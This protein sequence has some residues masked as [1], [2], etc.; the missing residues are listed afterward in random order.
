M[1]N[2]TSA[3]SS[4][5]EMIID[6]DL[7][8]EMDSVDRMDLSVNEQSIDLKTSKYRLKLSLPQPVDPQKGKAKWN[9]D[10][11]KF[12]LCLVLNR[13]FDFVNF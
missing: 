13:E 12:V 4:C 7:P 2:K 10:S 1:A 3:T 6:I 11:K 8:D 9:S 5:E